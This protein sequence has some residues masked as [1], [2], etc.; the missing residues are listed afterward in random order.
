MAEADDLKV[1]AGIIMTLQIDAEMKTQSMFTMFILVNAVFTQLPGQVFSKLCSLTPDY[2]FI[3]M[4]A[5]IVRK[6]FAPTLL[7]SDNTMCPP[8]LASEIMGTSMYHL[9]ISVGG[10]SSMTIST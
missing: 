6:Y 3:L 7:R 10:T 8:T 5:H 1:V 2:I 9:N 4:K